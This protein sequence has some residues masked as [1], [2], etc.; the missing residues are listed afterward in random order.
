[1]ILLSVNET[2]KDAEDSSEDCSY[3]FLAPWERN[4][5]IILK[6]SELTP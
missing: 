1:M 3:W 2:V 5:K 4:P 6:I